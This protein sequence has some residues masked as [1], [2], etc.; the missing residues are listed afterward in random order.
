MAQAWYTN[1]YSFTSLGLEVPHDQFVRLDTSLPC[2]RHKKG[3]AVFQHIRAV[4]RHKEMHGL[5]VSETTQFQVLV[6]FINLF[7]GIQTQRRETGD[8]VEYESD[9]PR[10]I[11][12]MSELARVCRDL[13]SAF[14]SANK[15][16]LIDGMAHIANKILHDIMLFSQTLDPIQYKP[17]T[18]IEIHGVLSPD[19]S[20]VIIQNDMSRI[21]AFSFHHYLHYLLAEMMK[22]I[23]SIIPFV[24][25]RWKGRTLSDFM[26]DAVF[27]MPSEQEHEQFKGILIEWPLQKFAVLAMVRAE[28]WKKNGLTMRGQAHH[29]RDVHIREGTIDEEFFLLQAA[30]SFYDPQK[31]FVTVIERFGLSRFFSFPVRDERVWKAQDPNPRQSVVLLEDFVRLVIDLVSDTSAMN[32]WSNERYARRHVIQYL[33]LGKLTYSEL[34]KKLPERCFESLS[35]GQLLNDVADFREPS[36]TSTGFYTLKEEMYDEVDPYWRFY[37]RNEQSTV[38]N[39]IV[40]KIKADKKTDS[41]LILPRSIEPPPAGGPFGRLVQFLHTRVIGDMVFWLL[42]HCAFIAQPDV[43]PGLM[44]GWTEMPQ[45]DT[46]CELTLHLCMIAIHVDAENFAYCSVNDYT[47]AGSQSIFQN[48]WAM[49][50]SD[51]FKPYRAQVDYILESVIARLP[52][53]YTA[54]Y[55]SA[56][57]AEAFVEK[58]KVREQ[59]DAKKAAAARQAQVMRDFAKQQAQFA[60]MMD[61]GDD[62]DEDE[63]EDYDEGYGEQGNADGSAKKTAEPAVKPKELVSYGTCIV[64]QDDVT[65]ANPGGMLALFQPSRIVREAIADPECFKRII[66]APVCL[67]ED[68]RHPVVGDETGPIA[69]PALAGRFGVFMSSCN[70][71]MHDSCAQT[72]FDVT[73]WRHTQQVGRHHPENAVR[74]EYMCPLCKSLGNFVLPV[75][76]T[77]TP[78]RPPSITKDHRIPSLTAKIRVVSS[79]GLLRITESA[80]IWDHHVETGELVP[81]FV[82]CV[83]SQHTLDP[84]YRKSAMRPVSRMLDRMTNLLRSLSEQSTRM[85]SRK[86]IYVPDDVVGYTVSVAEIAQRGIPRKD[87]LTVAEQVPENQLNLIKHLVSMLQLELDVFFGPSFD[88]TPLRVGMFARLLPDWYRASTLPSPVLLRSPIS[89]VIECAAIAPDLLHAVI[90]M[91][92]YAELTRVMLGVCIYIKRIMSARQRPTGRI[93]TV[94]EPQTEDAMSVFSGFRWIMGNV[95]RHAGTFSDMDSTISAISERSLSKML[96]SFTLPFL[97]RAAIVH[98]AVTGTY[99]HPLPVPEGYCEY[100]KLL[101]LL[102]IPPPRESLS[103]PQSIETPIVAK[104]L[105]Q[106]AVQGRVV[107]HLE[108]PGTYELRTLPR[109]YEEMALR[110]AHARCDSCGLKPTYPAL[111]LFCSELVCLGGDCCAEGEQGECNVH[112][113]K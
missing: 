49:Q 60:A 113:R 55:R 3:L 33:A 50:T 48:L 53:E 30:L 112:M 110:Y 18:E 88:R 57:E 6:E 51:A 36:N 45:L 62:D 12:V 90:F 22:A 1:K 63:D 107:P 73:R 94:D 87:A 66:S 69:Y 10:A 86:S 105:T 109:T 17:P 56:R 83:F 61:M 95:L 93:Q 72:H 35:I 15:Q 74:M 39:K 41:A 7:V 46:V 78:M 20:Y 29:Y 77:R 111:C 76:P 82:D 103:N 42:A 54:D 44:A 38:L 84:A 14:R 52:E 25:G 65:T 106:W 37:T 68:T 2:F 31:F 23:P 71:L 40:E 108:F 70:H 5:I 27:R 59:S 19:S 4:L 91:S 81:W 9:W 80:K 16:Q 89:M 8:H 92:Y 26:R 75:E 100:R 96:Y 43:W 99:P 11:Q 64:C 34:C 13:G 97:R 102:A 98:Y 101:Y 58:E 21:E 104:W 79:E 47:H 85:R 24:D 67:D 32:D 28:M